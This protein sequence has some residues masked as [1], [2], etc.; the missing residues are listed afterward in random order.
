MAIINKVSVFSDSTGASKKA[1]VDSQRRIV[2]STSGVAGKFIY[3]EQATIPKDVE[4]TVVNYTVPTAKVFYIE[5]WRASG[6]ASGRY[7]LY[8][9]ATKII[10]ERSS[11][12]G[13]SV[14]DNLP[15]S[16]QVVAGEVIALK[17]V[18]VKL[19][20]TFSPLYIRGTL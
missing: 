18:H 7:T 3:G 15:N 6:Q 9:D 13:R 14:V 2:I 11:G 16:K 12:A 19:N 4:S 1:L 5:G 10:R 17:S 8:V 20:I